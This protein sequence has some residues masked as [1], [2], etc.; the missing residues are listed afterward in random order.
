M[1]LLQQADEGLP[2]GMSIICFQQWFSSSWTLGDRKEIAVCLDSTLADIA[3]A[4]AR[5]SGIAVENLLAVKPL[6]NFD[7]RIDRMDS[8]NWRYIHADK[9]K[10]IQAYLHIHTNTYIYIHA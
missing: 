9:H 7:G 10:Y 2:K 4:L 8:E 6:Y 1:Q 5:S 3:E